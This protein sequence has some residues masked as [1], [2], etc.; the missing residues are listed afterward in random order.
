MK[1]RYRLFKRRG[2]IFYCFDNQTERYVSL[3]TTDRAAAR[4]IVEAKNIALRQPALSR[5]I[6]KAYL[7]QSD[8]QIMTRTWQHAFDALIETKQGVTQLRWQRAIKEKPFDLIR[9]RVIIETHAGHFL[10]VLRVG[11]VSTNVHLR[12]VHNFC[13]D[14][15]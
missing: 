11:T 6:G 4:Q 7:A 3:Q 8:P 5:Q 9:D 1:D 13:L 10:E 12:K 14:L 15:S 2:R